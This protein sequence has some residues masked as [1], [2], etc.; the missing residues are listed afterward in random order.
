MNRRCPAAPNC[1]PACTEPGWSIARIENIFYFQGKVNRR[2]A[3]F[4]LTEI[5]FLAGMSHGPMLILPP[6]RWN[7]RAR[8]E[9]SNP[10]PHINKPNGTFVTYADYVKETGN[11]YGSEITIEKFRRKA[12]EC[13]EAL[14][15]LAKD[16][17]NARPD[18][19]V[20]IGND[21]REL[22]GPHNSPSLAVYCG[23]EIATYRRDPAGMPGWRIAVSKAYGMDAVRRYRAAPEAAEW[24]VQQLVADEFD[25]AT[26]GSV[27]EPERLGFGHAWGYVAERILKGMNAQILPVMINTMYPP[28]V[29]TPARCR[30]F[31]AALARAL[32]ELPGDLRVAVIASGGLSHFICEEEF[33]RG[34]L[35]AILGN[36]LDYLD[37]I[38]EKRLTSGS[39]EIRSWIT[40]AGMLGASRK[41]RWL[42]YVPIRRTPA[43]TGQGMAFGVWA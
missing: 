41:N 26:I 17:R 7:E 30:R 11:R 39:S 28:N 29:P 27:P 14:D 24:L 31:G 13:R 22:F 36:D 40:M 1:R 43:G 9:M 3:D 37:G 10:E 19:V 4:K 12:G 34:I 38:P 16:V 15:R 25:V 23:A 21:Q 42:S 8:D 6:E 33:D 20:I 35:D 32:G 18:I 2:L 5:A